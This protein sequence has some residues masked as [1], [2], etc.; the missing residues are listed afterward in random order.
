ME[1]LA[2]EKDGRYK[3]LQ[4]RHIYLHRLA[5]DDIFAAKVEAQPK[6]P[7]RMVPQHER[8]RQFKQFCVSISFPD[9]KCWVWILAR[10]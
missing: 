2:D 1:L 5:G 3:R 9:V 4:R 8:F 7:M 10:C 6:A